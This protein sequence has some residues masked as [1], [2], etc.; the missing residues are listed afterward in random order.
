MTA[1]PLAALA[2]ATAASW[3][4]VVPTD[5]GRLT[6][7]A[8]D[9]KAHWSEACREAAQLAR[10]P[11]ETVYAAL[12]EAGLRAN[13]GKD[14]PVLPFRACVGHLLRQLERNCVG[15][16]A[17]SSLPVVASAWVPTARIL[18]RHLLVAAMP[19]GST[20]TAVLS[21][22]APDARPSGDAWDVHV[23]DAD[24]AL[25]DL[26]SIWE[27]RMRE[28]AVR[29][30]DSGHQGA[31]LG[32]AIRA[33]KLEAKALE[34][35]Q[36]LVP[37]RNVRDEICILRHQI[38]GHL[39]T[40][41]GGCGVCEECHVAATYIRT[42][43]EWLELT[44]GDARLT[45]L[46]EFTENFAVASRLHARGFVQDTASTVS[47]LARR[48]VRSSSAQAQESSRG[49]LR[50]FF[51]AKRIPLAVERVGDAGTLAD[52]VTV[53]RK[54][55]KDLRKAMAC[56][57]GS[58]SQAPD[59]IDVVS[60]EIGWHPA[61][62]QPFYE[63]AA[64]HRLILAMH[65]GEDMADLLTGVRVVSEAIEVM[66][67]CNRPRTDRVRIGHG[68]AIRVNA[69]AWYAKQG[70]ARPRLWEHALDLLWAWGLTHQRNA[71]LRQEIRLRWQ[72]ASNQLRGCATKVDIAAAARRYSRGDGLCEHVRPWP[73]GVPPCL[74]R[75][76]CTGPTEIR[77]S[78]APGWTPTRLW[79]AV[80][81]HCQRRVRRQAVK[82]AIVEVCP[83]SNADI[84]GL[85]WSF[86]LDFGTRHLFG[87]ALIV[88]IGSD[89]PGVL[90]TSYPLEQQLLKEWL[91]HSGISEA[92]ADAWVRNQSRRV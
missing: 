78:P 13:N 34:L 33:G 92:D 40:C 43:C 1:D 71:A 88:R 60:R 66:R 55:A 61:L 30:N 47:D 56:T 64:K 11:L 70:S 75:P 87:N 59:G 76:T 73:D 14:P 58:N 16:I 4:H 44:R 49:S 15:A 23:H 42:R 38:L 6:Q 50:H 41:S 48:D 27:A 62:W 32:R 90:A 35:R 12:S 24:A 84:S 46:A 3:R 86:A 89:D 63:E 5:A 81:E 57:R 65:A 37:P 22:T 91:P 31:Q 2:L 19:A 45:G 72:L 68:I 80:V 77:P 52:T 17:A 25:G 51:A 26:E 8:F 67:F 21:V 79:L 85:G 74:I 9:S 54:A 28:E 39:M 36:G 69:S 7:Q 18:G 83:T 10:A 53:A 82:H 29:C 20:N